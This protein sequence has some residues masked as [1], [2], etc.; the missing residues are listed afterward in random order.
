MAI[1]VRACPP[2]PGRLSEGPRWHDERGELLWVDIL[3]SSVHRGRWSAQ[4]DLELLETIAL[5]RHVGA[6]AP[7]ADGGYVVAAGGGFVFVG[8]DRRRTDLAQPAADDPGVRMNDGA[9]D[10]QGRFWAGDDGLRRVA[11]RRDPVPP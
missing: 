9:C 7:C 11:G 2:A 5:D 1:R 10:P 8:A 4:D 6:V 3:G